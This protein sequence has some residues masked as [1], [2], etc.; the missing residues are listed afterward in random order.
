M[1][2]LSQGLFSFS[3]PASKKAGG[4]QEIGRG[5]CQDSRN[6]DNSLLLLVSGSPWHIWLSYQDKL[7][8]LHFT[9]SIPQ[10]NI[11]SAYKTENICSIHFIRVFTYSTSLMTDHAP[12]GCFEEPEII[13]KSLGSS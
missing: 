12:P 6:Q 1:F 9:S 4:A 8:A 2:I 13:W 5:H 10:G 11:Y 7:G 3:C